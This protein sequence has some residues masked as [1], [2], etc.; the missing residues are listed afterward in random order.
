VQKTFLTDTKGATF[1]NNFA[2]KNKTVFTVCCTTGVY[3]STG[4]RGVAR[5]VAREGQG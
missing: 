2:Y 3:S 5:G 4:M 1:A